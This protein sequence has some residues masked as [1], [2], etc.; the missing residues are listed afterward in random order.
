MFKSVTAVQA[1]PGGEEV[2]PK[3]ILCQ[4][5]KAGVCTKGKKCKYSHDL[6]LEGKN[7]KI[8]YYVDPRAGTD[9]MPDTIVTCR[10]FVKAVETENYGWLW[11]CPNNGANC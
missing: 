8:D 1:Q 4:F 7:T 9:K 10:D 11:E 5:F 3:K 2:D 6:S